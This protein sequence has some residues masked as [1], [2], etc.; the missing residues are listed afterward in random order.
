ME[1]RSGMVA[2]AS[3]WRGSSSLTDTE[4]ALLEATVGLERYRILTRRPLTVALG[5]RAYA[6]GLCGAFLAL[7]LTWQ[8]GALQALLT[9]LVAAVT[10]V[11]SLAAHEAGHLLFARAARGVEPQMLVLRWSGG[12]SVVKGRFA[13]ARS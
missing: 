12:V 13:D 7:I 8:N 11:L 3:L 5:P 2:V 4:T 1:G 6:P 10:L 9:A